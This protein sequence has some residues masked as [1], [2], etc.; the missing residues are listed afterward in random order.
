MTTGFQ[1]NA[2]HK[3]D[4]GVNPWIS[5]TKTCNG[6][7][8]SKTFQHVMAP[9]QDAEADAGY[10]FV[11][12]RKQERYSLCLT[13]DTKIQILTCGSDYD[14]KMSLYNVTGGW[15][16][17]GLPLGTWLGYC[18]DCGQNFPGHPCSQNTPHEQWYETLPK[19]HYYIIVD[20]YY[21]SV[22][23]VPPE[24]LKMEVICEENVQVAPTPPS[25]ICDSIGGIWPEI[26]CD[27]HRSVTT[28]DEAMS[29]TDRVRDPRIIH[30]CVTEDTELTILTCGTS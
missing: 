3:D 7:L 30:L 12:W 1:C 6:H 11:G 13:E 21:D 4:K 20:G 23:T 25:Q 18:D 5:G 28:F 8:S 2:W 10:C 15:N 27:G 26:S 16:D 29:V 22:R 14:V 24:S 17:D 9:C 19:G